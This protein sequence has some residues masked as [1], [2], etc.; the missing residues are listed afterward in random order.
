MSPLLTAFKT[1]PRRPAER[2]TIRWD[3]WVKDCSDL[4]FFVVLG[5]KH[6]A[7]WIS[8][9]LSLASNLTV[10]HRACVSRTDSHGNLTLVAI[11]YWV[12]TQ[13]EKPETCRVAS[14]VSLSHYCATTQLPGAGS[15][16]VPHIQLVFS[17]FTHCPFSVK[18]FNSLHSSS[19]KIGSC[20]AVYNFTCVHSGE[21][22]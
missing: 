21:V 20:D 13:R 7:I 9:S 22:M 3:C 19:P 8:G 18:G 1:L 17:S 16:Q 4:L 5:D 14:L 12:W 2:T 15:F 11:I 6:Q 10:A